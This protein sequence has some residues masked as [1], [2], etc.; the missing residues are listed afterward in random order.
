MVTADFPA[1]TEEKLPTPV[2]DTPPPSVDDAPPSTPE[3]ETPPAPA[4]ETPPEP[5]AIDK[6]TADFLK[7]YGGTDT[8]ASETADAP[9]V[10]PEVQAQAEKLA[11]QMIA[12][13]GQQQTEQSEAQLYEN[14]EKNVAIVDAAFARGQIDHE[15]ALNY[16]RQLGA[17]LKASAGKVQYG[18]GAVD[19]SNDL[20]NALSSKLPAAPAKDITAKF[21]SGAYNGKATAFVE[22]VFTAA[23]AGYF[24]KKQRDEAIA[25]AVSEYKAKVVDPLLKSPPENSDGA[26]VPVTDEDRLLGDPNTPVSTLIQIRTRQKA[27]G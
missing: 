4:D 2:D 19:A 17:Q 3:D 25:Q 23:R 26:G 1:P 5:S 9:A 12:Q 20:V 13:L 16:H 18:K 8:P 7:E 14:Y 15:T 10:D 27:A 11:Q 6:A 22:D 21:K 24:T